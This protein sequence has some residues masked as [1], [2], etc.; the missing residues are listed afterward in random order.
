MRRGITLLAIILIVGNL[1]PEIQGLLPDRI[2]NEP[3]NHWFIKPGFKLLD[4]S[5]KQIDVTFS[6]WWKMLMDDMN[7]VLIFF[8]FALV[9]EDFNR[10][11]FYI[12]S[13]FVIYHIIDA[14]MLVWD[15]KQT[16]GVYWILIFS[17]IISILLLLRRHKMK[18]VK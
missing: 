12:I 13:I 15:F 6:W 10:T 2:R 11:L 5:G 4:A 1:L 16:N 9:A 7:L 8:A 14:F 18:M 17:M 3:I